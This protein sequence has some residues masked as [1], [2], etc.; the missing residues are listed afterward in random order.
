[1]ARS[2]APLKQTLR[3]LLPHMAA[4]VERL[5]GRNLGTGFLS[6]G[7]LLA[8]ERLGGARSIE[9]DD[10]V[11]FTFVANDAECFEAAVKSVLDFK[12]RTPLTKDGIALWYFGSS[13]KGNRGQVGR[14]RPTAGQQRSR[15]KPRFAHTKAQTH[16]RTNAQTHKPH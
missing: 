1:M 8:L 11:D 6:C 3:A 13:L 5:N 7:S 15:P 16:E 14:R 2:V 4:V 10:D 12:K 9:A